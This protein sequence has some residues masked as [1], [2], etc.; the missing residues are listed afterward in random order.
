MKKVIHTEAAPNAIGPYSQAVVA[1]GFLFTSG[2]I[3]MDPA[4]G[5][6]DGGDV[7]AQTH[8]VM[9]NLEAVLTAG[10]ASFSSVV[11]TVIFLKSMSD[12]ETVNKVYSEWMGSGN[13]PARSTVEV[14]RLPKDVS[15]EIE[16]CATLSE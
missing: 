5:E 12:F 15:V 2:Q 9:K 4:T 8:R 7:E 14:S 1:N 3:A 13:F 10:G 11:K 16:M 6:V